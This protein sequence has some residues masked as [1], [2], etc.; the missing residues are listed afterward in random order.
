MRVMPLARPIDELL[1]RFEA[2][3]A[4]LLAKGDEKR[5]FHGI[6]LRNTRAV[7]AEIDRG[8]FLDVEWTER[9]TV[10][11]AN[12]Y[13]DVLEEW[14][15]AGTS[16]GPWQ[17]AFEAACDPAV[18]PLRHQLVG[19]NAHLNFDLPQALLD[20]MSDEGWAD[21]T[22]VARRHTDFAHI[23]TVAVRRVP[24]EYRRLLAVESPGDR[25]LGDRLLYPLNLVAS[26]RWLREA[27]RKA[28]RNTELLE[29]ARRQGP[30]ALDAR[31]R[32]LEQR[33]R[34]KVAEL[35]APGQVLLK[36]GVR[37][38]GVELPPQ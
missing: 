5:H 1:A 23:D 6:Y 19:L 3:S 34:A 8:G 20:V 2:S 35:L 11:F 22:L 37:G 32:Q 13:L 4:L 29:H 38:F 14:E 9:W 26:A 16:P 12:R 31:L 30:A 24:E 17:L 7:K 25:T 18:P 28:W 10:A 36:L 15:R 33:S 27:R 21:P